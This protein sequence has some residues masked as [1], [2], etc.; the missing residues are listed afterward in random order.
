MKR[1]NIIPLLLSF[2][3][4]LSS[5]INNEVSRKVPRGIL[6]PDKM[7]EIL[8]DMHLADSGV[9]TE[10]PDADSILSV[11]AGYYYAILDKHQVAPA[12]FKESMDFYLGRPTL[13]QEV[14]DKVNEII[15]TMQG[16]SIE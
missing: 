14:Y 6:K 4:L 11:K 2:L 3:L 10:I 9:S 15:N 1:E 5:C 12:K 7:A 16:V 13:L 8:A